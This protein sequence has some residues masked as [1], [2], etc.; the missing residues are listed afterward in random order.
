MSAPAVTLASR[1]AALVVAVRNCE[2]TGNTEW[3]DKHM[4]KISQLVRELL[5]HGSGLDA[6]VTLDVERSTGACL[7]LETSFHHMDEN[8][9][10][11]GWTDHT[12]RVRASLA[13]GLTL[14]ISGRD[15]ND[16][17]EYIHEAFHYALS[18]MV[19]P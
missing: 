7:V 14:T 10:Y 16:V 5:P 9:F 17:K 12:V 6:G 18:Q 11:D 19:L 1:L 2:R 15:R 4:E 8:G 13:L 3:R